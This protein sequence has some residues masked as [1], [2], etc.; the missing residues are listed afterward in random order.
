MATFRSFAEYSRALEKLKIPPRVLRNIGIESATAAQKIAQR[1]ASRDLGGD[2][3]FSGWDPPLDTRVKKL[4]TG[5]LIQPTRKSAGPWTV[6]N[7]GR[8]SDGG[9]GLFQGPSIR[10]TTGRT[11]RRKDGSVAT[12]RNRRSAKRWNG[13]TRGKGT[14]DR[15][16]AEFEK[17]AKKVA[18]VEMRKHFN[19][20]GVDV[21]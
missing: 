11:R 20:S 21:D 15:A 3:K 7:S 18:D 2:P 13:R 16:A 1:E 14:A 19:R 17:N 10:V 12:T 4:A 6:A 8:N 9:V 5:A